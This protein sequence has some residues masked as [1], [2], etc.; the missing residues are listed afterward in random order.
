MPFRLHGPI[1]A[2]RPFVEGSASQHNYACFDCLRNC[3]GVYVF[4]N[5]DGD[6]LYVGESH[7]VSNRRQGLKTRISQHYRPGDTG[8]N[9]RISYCKEHCKN[10]GGCEPDKCKNDSEP[11]FQSFKRLLKESMIW[12][13]VADDR[14]VKAIPTIEYALIC[15]LKPRYNKE[16][17]WLRAVGPECV[18]KEVERMRTSLRPHSEAP[19]P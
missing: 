16:M 6:V 7:K 10:I 11:S 14:G 4:A 8:G 12:V 19:R 5:E 2:G 15:R 18:Y 1:D 13:L 3:R 17:Q 9:F